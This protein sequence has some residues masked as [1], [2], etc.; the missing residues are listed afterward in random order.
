MSHTKHTTISCSSRHSRPKKP[1]DS[2]TKWTIA[3]AAYVISWSIIFYISWIITRE[4]PSVLEGCILSPGV[5]EM[6]Y[7]AVLKLA[8]NKRGMTP[9]K[10]DPDPMEF[11][12]IDEES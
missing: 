12:D 8:K 5:V 6:G 2:I 10:D 9:S 4:E 3:A 7:T 11:I 1:I